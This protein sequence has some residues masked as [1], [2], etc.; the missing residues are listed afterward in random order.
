MKK[1]KRVFSVIIFNLVVGCLIILPII[2]LIVPGINNINKSK[3]IIVLSSE[4]LEKEKE[5][6]NVKYN[7]LEIEIYNKYNEQATLIE[8]KYKQKEDEINAKYNLLEKEIKAKYTKTE[9]EEG[10][11]EEQVAMQKELSDIYT[12]KT[13]ELLQNS[14]DKYNEEQAFVSSKRSEL[15]TLYNNEDNEIS[16][17]TSR[18]SDKSRIKALGVTELVWGS[19]IVFVTIVYLL[20]L[21][22]I[23]SNAEKE[24]LEDSEELKERIKERKVIIHEIVYID[25][26]NMKYEIKEALRLLEEN[27]F[28][29][30][31]SI[32]K[33]N[34]NI[35]K[36]LTK[37]QKWIKIKR[38]AKYK[39]LIN[40]LKQKDESIKYLINKYQSDLNSYEHYLNV[41]PTSVIAIMFKFTI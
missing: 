27:N 10:W 3:D 34:K 22:N 38:S 17:L 26:E 24:V 13:E 16:Y 30:M 29:E 23:L 7:N 11:Y 18:A 32:I 2:F 8:N 21:F 9:K 33:N 36:L 37:A 5:N 28:K 4:D 39:N 20:I 12:P 31:A 1:K 40:E 19:I 41:F 14:K 25:S 35:S 15:K 6:I